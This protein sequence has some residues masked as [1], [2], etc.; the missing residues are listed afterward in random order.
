M[1]T[2]KCI[3]FYLAAFVTACAT[4]DLGYVNNFHVKE[5][6][7]GYVK[8]AWDFVDGNT[9]HPLHKYS[10]TVDSDL[11]MEF[12]C[13]KPACE[14]II[15]DL[16]ACVEHLF[17]LTPIFYT[18][19]G[20]DMDG[21]L[22]STTGYTTDEIPGAVSNIK[23]TADTDVETSFKWNQPLVNPKCVVLYRLCYRLDGET[24]NPCVESNTTTA[25][26]KSMSA[27]ATYHVTVTPVTPSGKEGPTIESVFETHDGVPGKPEDVHVGLITPE[28]IQLLWN[29]PS[30][31][32]LCLERF[33]ITIGETHAKT[34]RPATR[35]TSGYDNEFTFTP[36]FPCT[37]YTID[38]CSANVAEMT[39]D[40]VIMYASTNETEPQE[41]PTV[42]VTPS[43]PDTIEVSWGDNENDRCSGSFEV[44]WYDGVHPVEQCQEVGGDGDNLVVHDLLPCSNYDFSVT[45]HSPSGTFVSNSTFNS[46]STEDVRPGPVVNLQVVNVDVTEMTVTCEPPAVDPQ[47]AKEV[48]TRIIDENAK[49]QRIVRRSSFQE[50]INGLEPCTDYRIL[51]STKSPGGLQSEERET[52]SRTLD[53]LPSEPQA[54]N[55]TEV[56]TTSV[57]LQWFRPLINPRCATNYTLKWKSDVDNDIITISETSSFKTVYIVDGLQPC[58]IHNF[59]LNAESSVGSGLETALVQA[60]NC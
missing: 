48:I 60:T 50:T 19:T 15:E 20:D 53:D 37:N 21:T 30:N 55:V 16:D 24:D 43:G 3:L 49:S 27:C 6:G 13:G 35:T 56:T 41:P 31:N 46:T 28:T 32:F 12:K 52:T 44:C 34:V 9:S 58:T 18:P 17:E 33:R 45:V 36:L 38:I 59:T 4:V 54:F 2:M 8:V 25:T 51:V 42:T 11:T 29:N 1:P 22:A 14:R 57:T 5:F 47:C 7:T 39:S 23:V 26:V 10:L 40:K